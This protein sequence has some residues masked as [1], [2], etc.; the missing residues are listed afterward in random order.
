MAHAGGRP[1]KYRKKFAKDIIN[2]FNVKFTRTVKEVFYYKNGDTKEKEVEVAN[3]LP[4]FSG[5]ANFIGVNKDTIVEWS[6]AKTKS[7]KLK[8]PEFSVAYKKA[9]EMQERMWT[10]NSLRGLYN[11]AFTIFMGKNVFGWHD[12]QE[13]DH[14]SKGE[15]ITGFNYLPPKPN[16]SNDTSVSKTA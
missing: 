8:Y 13:V 2:Y 3:E 16:G 4:L 14:T 1:T 11:P 9:K 10:N 7:G 5:F 6:E 15:K 12:K